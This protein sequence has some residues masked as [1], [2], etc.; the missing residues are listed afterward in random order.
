MFERGGQ[1]ESGLHGDV[2]QQIRLLATLLQLVGGVV[3]HLL[4]A[5]AH[6]LHFQ[7]VDLAAETDQLTGQKVVLDLHLPLREQGEQMKRQS[8]RHQ[9]TCGSFDSHSC[10]LCPYQ[11]FINH[12]DDTYTG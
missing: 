9:K 1:S 6:L 4:V 2:T 3:Q 8:V 12:Q 7:P 10:A 5:V 11:R